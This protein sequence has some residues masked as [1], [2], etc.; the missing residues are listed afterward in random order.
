MAKATGE[1]VW[2]SLFAVG[3]VMAALFVPAL[4]LITGFAIPFVSIGMVAGVKFSGF[5][6]V[7]GL[8][9]SWIGR[10]VLFFATSLSLFHCAHRLVHTSKDLGLRAAHGPIAIIC[11]GGAIVATLFALYIIWVK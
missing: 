9:T 10:L 3:G 4:I 8:I 7:I 5:P 2:W 11:Y 1:I 6:T